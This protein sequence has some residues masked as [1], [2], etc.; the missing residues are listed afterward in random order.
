[1]GSNSDQI[2][3]VA[4]CKAKPDRIEETRAALLSA[5]PWASDEEG[6]IEYVLHVDR[7]RPTDFVFYEVYKDAAAL[8]AHRDMPQ[9]KELID[10]LGE[11]L[12]EP[13]TVILL[14]R[15]A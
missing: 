9:F 4:I 10:H 15:L 2:G 7:D 1:M 3:M 8:E 6:C 11:L 12:S 5:V 14:E 13:A